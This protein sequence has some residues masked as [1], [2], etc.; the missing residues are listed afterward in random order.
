MSGLNNKS[1][2]V[3][4]KFTANNSLIGTRQI[5]MGGGLLGGYV[6]TGPGS[7]YRCYI[8]VP[9]FDN[10][11]AFISLSRFDNGIFTDNLIA[12]GA[13]TLVLNDVIRLNARVNVAD[14]S[15]ELFQNGVSVG[16]FVD[17]TA[18]RSTSGSPFMGR[19]LWTSGAAP[20]T[21]DARI[22]DFS[23]GKL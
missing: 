18:N 12:T 5:Y 6:D 4:F 20:G 17:N 9:F 21:G 3:Q 1:Q 15:F 10:V 8:A 14:I 23:C 2:F 13:G 19:R 7:D 11:N 16:T 22:D